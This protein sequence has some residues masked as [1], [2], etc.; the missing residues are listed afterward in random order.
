MALLNWIRGRSE[1]EEKAA[2]LF[3][4]SNLLAIASLN[5]LLDRHAVLRLGL[6]VRKHGTQKWDFFVTAAGVFV[7]ISALECADGERHRLEKLIFRQ[8]KVTPSDDQS[9]GI[10]AHLTAERQA[11]FDLWGRAGRAAVNDCSGFVE[12]VVEEAQPGRRA[13]ALAAAIGSW[14]LWNIYGESP[15]SDEADLAGAI[16]HLAI[17]NF[18]NYWS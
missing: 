12:K 17:S 9:T 7:A 18:A 3:I 5:P 16:G 10:A 1:W 11:L 2:D 13:N 14:V 15:A 6:A 8:P 4:Q